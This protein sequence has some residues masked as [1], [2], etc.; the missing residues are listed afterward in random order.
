MPS[1]KYPN[2]TPIQRHHVEPLVRALTKKG[3]IFGVNFYK[4]DNSLRKMCC[5]LGVTKGIIGTGKK[6][7]RSDYPN[8]MTVY[9]MGKHNF[10]NVNL[11]TVVSITSKG[12]MYVVIE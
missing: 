6:W 10:R 5:R 12:N 7:D 9:D 3:Q 11:D 4:K 8:L 2:R 1:P